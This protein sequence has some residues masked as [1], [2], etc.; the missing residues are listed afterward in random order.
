VFPD[1]TEYIVSVLAG[2]YDDE[3]AGAISQAGFGLAGGHSSRTTPGPGG[4][5][6]P[7]DVHTIMLDAASEDDAR[8][9]V[10]AMLDSIDRPHTI[11]RV[12][13]VPE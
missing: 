4:E 13:S 7:V 2:P 3:L 1:R 11:E 10:T 5:L 12:E 9:Q 6:P 8:R